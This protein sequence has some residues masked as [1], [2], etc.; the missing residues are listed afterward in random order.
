MLQSGSCIG[1]RPRGSGRDPAAR[2]WTPSEVSPKWT[3]SHFSKT[4]AL[5]VAT[6][7]TANRAEPLQ[8]FNPHSPFPGQRSI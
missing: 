5:R 6:P 4:C 8:T 1:A 3:N 2:S 7:S